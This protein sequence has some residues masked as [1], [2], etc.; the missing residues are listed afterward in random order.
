M[1]FHFALLPNQNNTTKQLI[2]KYLNTHI[3]KYKDKF[4]LY[5]FV[6]YFFLFFIFFFFFIFFCFFIFFLFFIF[7]S[8]LYF[9]VFYIF[10][11]VP[12]LN[13]WLFY[14]GINLYILVKVRTHILLK[15]EISQLISILQLKK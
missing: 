14:W 5:F 4:I 3:I 6:F 10:I 13:R 7:F 15:I 11:L 2:Y 1:V 8:F 12:N 9:F